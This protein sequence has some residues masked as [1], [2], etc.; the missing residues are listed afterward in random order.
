MPAVREFIS[1]LIVLHREYRKFPMRARAHILIRFLTCPFL[2]VAR[3][4]PRG[5]KLLDIGAGH[6]VFAV[7]ARERR[8]TVT[9]ID[10]DAR[11][12]RRLGDIESVIGY[13]DC[14]RGTFDAISIIDVLY[15]LPIADWDAL[16]DRVQKR[17]RPGGTLIIKEHDPTSTLKQAVNRLQERL[18]SAGGLTL[19]ESFSYEAPEQFMRRLEAHG[20]AVAVAKRIDFG[21][22]HPHMLYV[23]RRE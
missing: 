14:I 6:G 2:R 20:F 10:P 12:V 13:D 16:L 11:K 8:A 1:A 18:A 17:L 23:A 22:P 4:V 5:A 9:A 15:K 7:L 3:H 21:Y 19:G